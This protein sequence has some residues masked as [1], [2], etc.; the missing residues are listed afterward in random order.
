MF[1]QIVEGYINAERGESEVDEK[2]WDKDAP[3]NKGKPPRPLYWYP[4][5]SLNLEVK[6]LLPVE[7][8]EWLFVRMRAKV[9]KHGR[10]DLE[11]TVLDNKGGVVAISTHSSLIMDASRNMGPGGQ[12]PARKETKL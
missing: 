6:E 3:E 8:V 10:L 1:P 12:K 4:T 2:V 9:I 5:L 7:G 11:V